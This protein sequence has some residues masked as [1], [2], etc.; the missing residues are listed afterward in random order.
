MAVLEQDM[1][2]EAEV[3]PNC[4]EWADSVAE[5]ALDEMIQDIDYFRERLSRHPLYDLGSPR[6]AW[7]AEFTRIFNIPTY[8]MVDPH[9][10]ESWVAE[11]ITEQAKRGETQFENLGYA[12]M[13]ALSFLLML[14]KPGNFMTL[15]L[16]RKIIPSYDYMRRM[17]Y[18]IHRLTPEGGIW[19][20]RDSPYLEKTGLRLYSSSRKI[21][22]LRV[23]EA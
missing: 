5:K 19:I 2:L 1:R 15:A 7:P 14:K 13:G 3:L 22:S 11:Q 20:C 6:P 8:I 16:D 18:H 4:L 17:A 10:R 9:I 21:K 23:F 12:K